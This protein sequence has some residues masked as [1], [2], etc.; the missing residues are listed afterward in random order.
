MRIGRR[1]CLPILRA[2]SAIGA[3]ALIAAFAAG[4]DH[5]RGGEG[6]PMLEVAAAAPRAGASSL[7]M[8]RCARCHDEDGTG[9]ELRGMIDG[10]PNF[11]NLHW[12]RQRSDAQLVVSILEGKGTRMPA[13]SD[14]LS[15]AEARALVSHIRSLV[16]G[17][18]V[19]TDD[20]VPDFQ[21]RFQALQEEFERLR[22]QFHELAASGK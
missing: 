16:P 4:R 6:P 22:K 7:F 18:M 9:A 19:G 3:A 1:I 12:Q 15:R 20:P 5:S 11:A 17:E 8:R 2:P 10:L 13:F 21:E 14:R